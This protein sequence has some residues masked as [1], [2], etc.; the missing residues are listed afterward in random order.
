MAEDGPIDPR[1]PLQETSSSAYPV[2]TEKNVKDLDGTLVLTE[3]PPSGGTARTIDLAKRHKKP[4]LVIDLGQEGHPDRVAKWVQANRIHILNAAGPRQS[5]RPG[6][7]GRAIAFLRVAIGSTAACAGVD[8][9]K[10]LDG[11]IVPLL[12][13]K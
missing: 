3:E 5:R 7:L 9:K 11:R 10:V 12:S 8:H 13:T 4:Y 2:R 6:I 1:Y